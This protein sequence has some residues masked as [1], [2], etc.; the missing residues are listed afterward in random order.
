MK[1]KKKYLLLATTL[2]SSTLVHAS[3]NCDDP[4]I[5]AYG[6]GAGVIYPLTFKV[7]C[8]IHNDT[9][10]T[11]TYKLE[12]RGWVDNVSAGGMGVQ[13]ETL[14]FSPGQSVTADYQVKFNVQFNTLGYH[15]THYEMIVS[16]AESYNKHW[17]GFFSVDH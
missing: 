12:Y 6:L 9:N 11:K 10:A 5:S 4:H 1:M 8:V 2:L 17:T 7:H 16:D 3:V 15:D 14:I 13:T